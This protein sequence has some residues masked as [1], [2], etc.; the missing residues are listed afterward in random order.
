MNPRND[1]VL[2]EDSRARLIGEIATV[3]HSQT[4]PP[5][6]KQAGLTLIGWLARRMPGDQTP[7]HGIR[8]ATLSS[9]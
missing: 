8:R 5:E 9:G 7:A 3:L 1:P 2:S 6:A 4:V